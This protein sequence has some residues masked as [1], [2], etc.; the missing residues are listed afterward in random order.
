MGAKATGRL[1]FTAGDVWGAVER[2][3]GATDQQIAELGFPQPAMVVA[4]LVLVHT[5]ATLKSLII[6]RNNLRVYF[7]SKGGS[8]SK[9]THSL[10]RG[11][12]TTMLAVPQHFLITWPGRNA[13]ASVDF[14]DPL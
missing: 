11:E 13:T 2:L 14:S 3:G 6:K 10:P 8:C 12:A 1:C 4:K 5:V 7:D 9:A